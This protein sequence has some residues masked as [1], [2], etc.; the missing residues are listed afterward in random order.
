[1]SRL[2]GSASG[3]ASSRW[4]AGAGF[5]VI[6]LLT[7]I[8]LIGILA[9][10][11]FPKVTHTKDNAVLA[12]MK[13]DLRNLVSAQESFFVVNQTYASALGPS[14]TGTVAVF[15]PSASNLVTLS[16]VTASGW[17]AEITNSALSGPGH[18]CGVFVGT[19]SAPD[20]SVTIPG[21]PL[22]S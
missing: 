14:A 21:T 2:A 4:V 11:T 13:S 17:A 19:A 10:I 12:G 16:S 9:A 8:A 15:V 7:V 22:C 6:E 3:P 18:R 20:P 1:M 5:T